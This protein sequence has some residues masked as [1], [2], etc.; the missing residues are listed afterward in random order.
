MFDTTLKNMLMTPIRFILVLLLC[1]AGQSLAQTTSSSLPS[2]T[3]PVR[4]L[5]DDEAPGW[6]SLEKGDFTRVNSSDDTW[7]WKADG[8]HCTVNLSV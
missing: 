7:T 2:T 3:G 8:L 1:L 4:A 5:I 6:R